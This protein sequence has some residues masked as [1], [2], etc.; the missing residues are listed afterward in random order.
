MLVRVRNLIKADRKKNPTSGGYP[1]S[2]KRHC[3]GTVD[4]L[5]RRYPVV[6]Q[7]TLEDTESIVQHKKAMC[8]EMAKA[9]TREAVILPLMKKS[10]HNRWDFIC[11]EAESVQQILEEYPAFRKPG[12]CM[13]ETGHNLFYIYSVFQ[14]NYD[15]MNMLTV[16]IISGDPV[17]T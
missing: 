5:L 4:L 6:Q 3:K 11:N 8:E 16:S 15:I 1:S 17:M 2:P 7:S 13:L 9:K 14:L 10:Y 12:N